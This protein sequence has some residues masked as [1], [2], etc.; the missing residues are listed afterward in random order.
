MNSFLIIGASGFVGSNV[1]NCLPKKS[2]ILIITTNRDKIQKTVKKKFIDLNIKDY[3]F[4]N[5]KNINKIQSYKIII[6]CAGVYFKGNNLKTLV[7][8]NYTIPKNLYNLCEG[9]NLIRYINL[10]TL[11][12]NRL[13]LYVHYKHKLSLYFKKKNIKNIKVIDL[14]VSHLYGDIRHKNEFILKSL[15]MFLNNSK[16]SNF[17]N[18]LQKRDFLHIDDFK[19]IFK[20]ILLYKSIKNYQKFDIKFNKSYTIRYVVLLIKKLTNSKKKI[21]FGALKYKKNEDFDVK[22][23]NNLKNKILWN[24]KISLKKGIISLI[25]RYKNE[26]RK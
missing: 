10:N 21:N 8:I 22:S 20:K 2:K 9:N 5:K 6:N 25:K 13:S 18:G 4:L 26:K 19:N 11:L 3:K 16:N 17:T 23:D 14:H 15:I 12:K 1:I 7:N 24:P